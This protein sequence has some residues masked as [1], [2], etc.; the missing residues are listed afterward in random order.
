MAWVKGC[1]SHDIQAYFQF[2]DELVMQNGLIYKDERIL[3][4]TAIRNNLLER[5]NNSQIG[6]QRML[7]KACETWIGPTW[8]KI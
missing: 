8:L 6:I 2:R 7:K 4:P 3:V 5:I 1:I